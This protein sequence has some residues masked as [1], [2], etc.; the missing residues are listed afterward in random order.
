MPRGK[1]ARDS[2]VVSLWAKAALADMSGRGDPT[3]QTASLHL[4]LGITQ[5]YIKKFLADIR[6][7]IGFLKRDFKSCLN[8]LRKDVTEVIERIDAL[9]R[10]IDSQAEV[11]EEPSSP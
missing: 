11:Q 4:V 1:T 7:E 5:D 2:S 6:Q 8:D 9:E 3:G 10:T